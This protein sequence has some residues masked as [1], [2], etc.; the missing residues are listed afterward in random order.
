MKQQRVRLFAK[1]VYYTMVLVAQ[2]VKNL[3]VMQETPVRSLCP[4]RSPEKGVA[5]HSSILAW[6]IP[7]TEEPG[8]YSPW[9]HKIVKH[10]LA[11]KQNNNTI[12]YFS[13]YTILTL[14]QNS[15]ANIGQFK[16]WI[17]LIRNRKGDVEAGKQVKKQEVL[18]FH[19]ELK[20][21]AFHHTWM[22]KQEFFFLS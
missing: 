2:M 1:K 17:K 12:L 5:T 7:W 15:H 22:I 4:G 11:T 14:K 8:G 21:V 10:D 13:K 6:K 16:S 9:D 19:K 3:P 20:M 18:I